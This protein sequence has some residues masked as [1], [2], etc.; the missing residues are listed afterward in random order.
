MNRRRLD[1][2][3]GGA[4][5]TTVNVVAFLATCAGF[6]FASSANAA[7]E[8]EQP[9]LNKERALILDGYEHNE[10][11]LPEIAKDERIAAFIHKGSDGLPANYH[12]NRVTAGP[13]RELCRKT[14]RNYSVSREL[15]HTRRALAKALGLKWG[16][17]HLARPGNPV[18][19]A[20]HFL[21]YADPADDELMAIDIEDNDPEKWMS[22]SDADFELSRWQLACRDCLQM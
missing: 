9:W 16:A 13:D 3:L 21:D 12:C 10:F 8:F 14:W 6:S 18:E 20:N 2:R 15:Y 11:S 7:S 17:Y 4:C 5:K 22:L 19:Q 1:H